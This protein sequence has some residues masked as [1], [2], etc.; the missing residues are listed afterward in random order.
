MDGGQSCIAAKRFIVAGRVRAGFDELFVERMSAAKLGDPMSEDTEL[1]PLARHDLRD[2]LHSQVTRSIA[3]GAR[4]LLGGKI[5]SGPGAYYPPTVLT[6]VG[7]GMP[8]YEEELFVP[9]PPVIPVKAHQG[10]I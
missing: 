4:C 6:D 10:A 7:S 3:M 9:V 1:G 8:A 5:P 2:A